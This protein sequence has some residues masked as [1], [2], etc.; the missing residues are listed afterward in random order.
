MMMAKI[1][2]PPYL[3]LEGQIHNVHMNSNLTCL[4]SKFGKRLIPILA[5]I[6]NSAQSYC[7]KSFESGILVGTSDE[8]KQ[9]GNSASITDKD[10]SFVFVLNERLCSP[11]CKAV[12]NNSPVK[13]EMLD[14]DYIVTIKEE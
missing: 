1:I 7:F 12:E 5:N 10:F 6:I 8:E 13:I 14:G 3:R 9:T 11:E 2:T 4:D